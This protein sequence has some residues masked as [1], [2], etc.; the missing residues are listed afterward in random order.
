MFLNVFILFMYM[1]VLPTCMALHYIHAWYLRRP[2][3]GI[4]YTETGVSDGYEPSN[5][6]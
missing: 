1:D 5:G 2:E 6:C 4:T 3:E